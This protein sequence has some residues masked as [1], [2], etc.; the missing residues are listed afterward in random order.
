MKSTATKLLAPLVLSLALASPSYAQDDIRPSLERM[1]ELQDMESMLDNSYRQIDQMFSQ[2]VA[3]QQVTEKTRP[4]FEKYHQKFRLIMVE[5]LNWEKLKE[6][7]MD[8]YSKVYSKEEIEALI[9]FYETPVGQKF[10]K[11]TPELMHATVQVMQGFTR[12]M[13][14]KMQALQQ[15]MKA[16]LEKQS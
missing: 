11:K 5:G 7:M 16:E 1:F 13:F 10:L 2:M 14:P 3:Q 12:D 8:A 6:P 4:I 9:K 15:E